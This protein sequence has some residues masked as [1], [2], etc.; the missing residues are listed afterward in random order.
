M[1][2][3]DQ[4]QS[5]EFPLGA[6]RGLQGDP[7]KTGD[8]LELVGEAIKQFKGA[9]QL[10][11]GLA[12]VDPVES[13]QAGGGFV[14]LG[15]L[16]HGAGTKRIHVGVD[17]EVLLRKAHEMAHDVNLRHLGQRQIVAQLVGRQKV[18]GHAHPRVRIGQRDPAATL[19]REFVDYRLAASH[20]TLSR[21]PSRAC[22]AS[23]PDRSVKASSR[24]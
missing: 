2:G 21:A 22:R 24:W 17:R 19:L 20:Q 18:L 9:L 12:R 4:L 15:V 6:G 5:D 7:G 23:A 14:D 13:L 3:P 1:M 16:L 8:F 11:V 10:L